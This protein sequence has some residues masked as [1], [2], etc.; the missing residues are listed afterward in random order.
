MAMWRIRYKDRN[1]FMR[2]AYA[3]Q[4]EKPSKTEAIE[5]IRNEASTATFGNQQSGA[6]GIALLI[7]LTIVAVEEVIEGQ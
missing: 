3:Q 1:G 5:A 7:G 2:A 4:S 6:I